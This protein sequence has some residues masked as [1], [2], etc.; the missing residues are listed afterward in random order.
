VGGALSV[1]SRLLQTQPIDVTKSPRGAPAFFWTHPFLPMTA[2]VS[3]FAP[4]FQPESETPQQIPNTKYQIQKSLGLLLNRPLSTSLQE[5]GR[6]KFQQ[7]VDQP[8]KPLAHFGPRFSPLDRSRMN[9]AL[10]PSIHVPEFVLGSVTH[11]LA[12]TRGKTV[13]SSIRSCRPRTTDR[14]GYLS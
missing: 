11:R 14:G 7:C 12:P 4:V 6:A 13:L 2:C 5:R 1:K 8:S 10:T 9:Q 3:D